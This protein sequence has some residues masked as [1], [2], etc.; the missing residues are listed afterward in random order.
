MEQEAGGAWQGE[1]ERGREGERRK[2]QE[3]EPTMDQNHVARRNSKYQGALEP[4]NKL[5]QP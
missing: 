2:L 1:R 5:V 4:E 3:E